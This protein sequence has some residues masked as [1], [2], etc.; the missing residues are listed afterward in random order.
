MRCPNC[1]TD[2]DRVVDSRPADDGDAVR[3]RRECRGCHS[4][5][6]TFERIELPVLL[7]GKRDGT[8][9]PFD[10]AKVRD[11]M[12]RAA[13]GR[14]DAETIERAVAEVEAALREDGTREVESQR[15]GL[16]VLTQL[17]EL[18]PVSYVRYAS[19]YK[20][21]Q[22]AED[23]EAELHRLRAEQADDQPRAELG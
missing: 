15:V 6:T 18:D 17:R 10:R 8:T 12:S 4:R 3:R 23:F 22:G 20:D 7:V 13:K 16:Q 11:G 5:F 1:G 9:Q 19:V 14:I 2:D 21:F